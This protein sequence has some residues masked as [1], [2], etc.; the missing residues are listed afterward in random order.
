[1]ASQNPT[2][3]AALPRSSFAHSSPARKASPLSRMNS[4]SVCLIVLRILPADPVEAELDLLH[5]HGG[6]HRVED[7]PG[8]SARPRVVQDP[9]VDRRFSRRVQLLDPDLSVVVPSLDDGLPPPEQI[10][11]LGAGPPENDA[12]PPV[13]LT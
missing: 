2:L 9:S 4:T 5:G 6:G 7:R 12:A 13:S 8:P 11:R 3:M 1:M 10:L